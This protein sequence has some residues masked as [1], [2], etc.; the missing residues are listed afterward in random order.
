MTANK[1]RAPAA[2]VP[3]VI[4][5]ITGLNANPFT[6]ASGTYTFSISSTFNGS[7]AQSSFTVGAVGLTGTNSSSWSATGYSGATPGTATHTIANGSTD[8]SGEWIQIQLPFTTSITQYAFSVWPNGNGT[9]L[10]A[11]T[12]CSLVGSSN[13]STWTIIDQQS[14]ITPNGLLH[15]YTCTG[16]P[17]YNYLRFIVQRLNGNDAVYFQ[18]LQYTGYK[19]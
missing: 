15:T 14:G 3:V 8:I 17:Y 4:T 12:Q 6:N 10:S 13:G 2:A 7:F 9:N 19:I 1:K 5:P 16:K 11:I 18:T